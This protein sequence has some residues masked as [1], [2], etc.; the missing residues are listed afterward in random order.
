MSELLAVAKEMKALVKAIRNKHKVGIG[1]KIYMWRMGTP[2]EIQEL[3]SN[4]VWKRF[5]AAIEKEEGQGT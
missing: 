5:C 1:E 4:S 2:P 3:D